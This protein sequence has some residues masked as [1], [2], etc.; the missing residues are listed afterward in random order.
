VWPGV[1]LTLLGGAGVALVLAADIGGT[2]RLE[3]LAFALGLAW[4]PL[5]LGVSLVMLR[6]GVWLLGRALRR[7]NP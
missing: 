7:P 5:L 4:G 1:V 3:A 6:V 2:P